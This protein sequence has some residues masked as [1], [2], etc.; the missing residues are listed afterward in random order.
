[1]QQQLVMLIRR[2]QQQQLGAGHMLAGPCIA[3]CDE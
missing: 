2:F 3:L 1:M